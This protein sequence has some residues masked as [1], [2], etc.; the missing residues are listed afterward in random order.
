VS[1]GEASSGKLSGPVSYIDCIEF[2][3]KK[4]QNG[5]LLTKSCQISRDVAREL[6]LQKSKQTL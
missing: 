6:D 4:L 3:E 5:P 1:A 2:N